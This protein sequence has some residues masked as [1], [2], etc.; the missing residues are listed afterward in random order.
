M[1]PS[2]AKRLVLFLPL[3]LIAV[4][5]GGGPVALNGGDGVSIADAQA[6]LA[7]HSLATLATSATEQ[8]IHLSPS[9]TSVRGKL[10]LWEQ[11]VSLP[12]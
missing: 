7:L 5:W 6:D 2:G 4:R 3:A 8:A 10:S 12:L 1:A 9:P 11:W